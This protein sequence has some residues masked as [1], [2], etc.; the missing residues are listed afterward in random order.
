M[1]YRTFLSTVHGPPSYQNYLDLIDPRLVEPAPLELTNEQL[2]AEIEAA[3]EELQDVLNMPDD[4]L[5]VVMEAALRNR[6]IRMRAARVVLTKGRAS[7][8]RL[9]K[10]NDNWLPWHDETMAAISMEI[11]QLARDRLDAIETWLNSEFENAIGPDMPVDL[12]AWRSWRRV[13]LQTTLT[14][15]RRELEDRRNRRTVLISLRAYIDT[16]QARRRTV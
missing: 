5:I 7:T 1:D 2:F 9:A 3:A 15:M 16:T 11:K 4:N 10:L 8:G 13:Y 14:Q 6:T 12:D